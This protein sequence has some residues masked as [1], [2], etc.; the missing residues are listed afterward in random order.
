MTC[1]ENDHHHRHCHRDASERVAFPLRRHC[2]LAYSDCD[3]DCRILCLFPDDRRNRCNHFHGGFCNDVCPL[4][5]CRTFDA[6]R[7][8]CRLI[9]GFGFFEVGTCK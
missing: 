5:H 3:A 4:R 6:C 9:G 2:T 8:H 7:R 1:G